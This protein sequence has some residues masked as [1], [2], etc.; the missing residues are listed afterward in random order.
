L[1]KFFILAW[2]LLPVA[3]TAYHYGPGQD[4]MLMDQVGEI[5]AKAE[6][7]VAGGNYG[8]AEQC[9]AQALSVLPSDRVKEGRKIRLEKAKAQMFVSKLPTAHAELESLVDELEGDTKANES[10][11][12][13]ARSTLANSKYYMT[14]LMRLE[15]QPKEKWEPM[16][17]AARQ[18]YRLL[19]EKAD[20]GKNSGG[21][22]KNREDL[23]A[24]IRL[25]RMD[26][27]DLQGLPL[28]SQ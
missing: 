17:E 21:G 23:E 22:K 18:N 12:D 16:I 25:A 26:L 4:R 2:L 11:V 8:E 1:R 24:S 14:W 10:L 6:K 19:A 27:S 5:V 3:A 9:Y 15:G 28:P 7:H 13:E 20:K